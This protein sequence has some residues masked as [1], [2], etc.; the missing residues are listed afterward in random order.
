MNRERELLN[1]IDRLRL[2]NMNL[3][4]K[5]YELQDELEYLSEEMNGLKLDLIAHRTL[6]KELMNKIEKENET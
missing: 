1:E 4:S 2:E 6:N 5:I 3:N